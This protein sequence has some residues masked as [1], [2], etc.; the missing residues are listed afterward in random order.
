MQRSCLTLFA[1]LAILLTSAGPI[2]AQQQLELTGVVRDFKI[3]HPD[4]ERPAGGYPLIQGMVKDTLGDDGRPVLNVEPVVSNDPDADPHISVRFAGESLNIT[5][6]KDLSNVVLD[7]SNGVEYKFDGL[8][9]LEDD[10]QVPA[11][12][13]EDI[14]IDGVWVKSANNASGDG[15]GYGEYFSPADIEIDPLWRIESP[16]TFDQWYRNVDGVNKSMKHSITLTDENNDGIFR[17]EASKH[18]GQSFFPIDD[19]KVDDADKIWG[20][21][22]NSHNYHFTYEVH[23]KFTYTDPA[24]RDQDLTFSFSGDD[25]VWVFINDQLVVDIGGVHS[26]KYDSVNVDDIADQIGLEPGKTYDFDFFFAER[27]T[28]ESNFTIE[29]TIQF[30][31][32]L[33]D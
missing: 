12:Q 28:T 9:G 14:T 32:P 27:H 7:L 13:P 21:E 8:T 15:P 22:G 4:F 2:H 23:T 19:D 31:S 33:Y 30:L 16:Q 3:A 17:Y 26:E 5:S 29:T 11:D 25:D 10:F 20:N 18:N 1:G 6:T 24:E